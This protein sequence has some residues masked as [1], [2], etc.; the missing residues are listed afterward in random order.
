M[1]TKLTVTLTLLLS[2]FLTACGQTKSKST[3]EK[4]PFDFDRID[5]IEISKR[6]TPLDTTNYALKV[7]TKEQ[8]KSFSDKWNKADKAELRKYLPSYNLT[9]YLKSGATRH[10]RV[11]GKYIKETNDY[12]FD[13]GD[14]NYFSNLYSNSVA[15]AITPDSTL[16]TG[17][18][19]V[20]DQ[21]T[22][23]KRQL[24]KTAEFYFIDPN[25]IVP[26][27]QFK[28]LELTDSEYEGKSYPMLVIR[29]DTK[30]TDSWSIA[31]EKSIG[32][33]LAL[34]VNDKLVIAP[35]VNSQITAGVSALNR[36]DY[37]KQ[38]IEEILKQI[39][40]ERQEK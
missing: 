23:F 36:T 9:V 37:T 15:S 17:W 39:E 32:G 29:F 13:F 38:D 22:N 30:G 40:N 10:F 2:I 26:I 5:R 31:T 7:L 19:Y 21:Q 20:T 4:S 34:I 14:D 8:V 18:Y 3:N 24:D 16:K 25:V 35:K 27:G 6:S 1:T 28:K 33:K 12:C 11:G